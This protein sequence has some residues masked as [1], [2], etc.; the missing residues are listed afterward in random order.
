MNDTNASIGRTIITAIPRSDELNEPGTL[1]SIRE[2][3]LSAKPVKISNPPTIFIPNGVLEF[4]SDINSDIISDLKTLGILLAI[5]FSLLVLP[6]F[7][8]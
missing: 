7:F 3:K 4:S 1:R 6:Y 8:G 2:M 5:L